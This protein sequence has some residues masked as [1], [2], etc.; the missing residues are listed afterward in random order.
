M[1]S[2]RLIL[3]LLLF[4]IVASAQTA[5]QGD[6]CYTDDHQKYLI[7]QNPSLIQQH[8]ELEDYIS[9]FKKSYNSSDKKSGTI[10]IPVV[11]HNITHD[12]GLAYVSKATIEAQIQSM[13][14][15]FKR[16]N[17]DAVSTRPLF[18]P[19]AASLDVEFRLA[20][21]DPNGK[22]TEG[23]V[24]KESPYSN[25]TSKSAAE[26]VKGVSYWNSKKYLNIWLIDE[27]EDNGDGTFIAGYAQFPWNGINSTYGVVIVDQSFGGGKRTLTHEVGHCF[28]LLHTFEGGCNSN[29][30]GA[31][32]RCCDTPPVSKSSFDCDNN[33][34]TCSNDGSSPYGGN[35]VDQ[36]EN[37]MSYS[38]CQNMFSLDQKTRIMA[39]LNS[40]N[41]ST[42]LAQLSTP[43][44]LA[45]TGTADPYNTPICVP[46][47]DFTYNKEYICEG[48]NVTFSDNSYN[49][50]PTGWSWVF[51]NG[52]PNASNAANPTVTY[53]TVGT[54]GATYTPSTTA[55]S[56]TP[57]TKNNIIT[58]S[59]LTANYSG[60]ITYE[61]F[62]NSSLFNTEWRI[63][64]PEGE[65]WVLTN[66]AATTGSNSVRIRNYFTSNPQ[67]EDA[68]I[69][70]SYNLSTAP[71]KTMRFK[72]AFAKKT[73]SDDDRLLIYYST[74]CGESWSVKTGFS[75]ANITTV[76]NQSSFFTPTSP[77]HWD[78]KVVDFSALGTATNI[79]FK[80][81]FKSGGGNNIYIDDINVGGFSLGVDE[82]NNIGEFN[83]YPNPTK[84]NTK[85]TF[86]LLK[87]VNQLNIKVRNTLG[88]EVTNIINNQSFTSGKYTLSIDEGRRLPAGIY[89]VEF[90]AD[91][92]IKTQKLIIQ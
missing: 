89:F 39:T 58:V 12:G 68:L 6:W 41:T 8:Q 27:I 21:I 23:I 9:N 74:N 48:G 59:S 4:T 76:P 11:V 82:F 15:D 46:I 86:N 16:L 73:T 90:N 45:A 28:S 75:G 2:T 78:E 57:V 63:E 36:Y 85:I 51:T 42:G 69:S 83:I 34:N 70:P 22:C 66:A 80:F 50:T 53:N 79:R 29:C 35:V 5:K 38:N 24:R 56:S 84:A 52:V 47:A 60:P 91:N 92:I 61:S 64:N 25:N 33:R 55:G 19:Y 77:S 71:S 43:S 18:S 10:I 3:A 37:Y 65:G 20:H 87:N 31:G 26:N 44:N 72:L 30:S 7:E 62:E 40:T 1:K 67:E 13:N 81:L 54:Y 17:A 14:N 49:A 88:Q 32:D